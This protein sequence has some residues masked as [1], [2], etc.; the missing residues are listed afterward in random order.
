MDAP[1]SVPKG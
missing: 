1:A